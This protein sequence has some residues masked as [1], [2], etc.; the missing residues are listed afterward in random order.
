MNKLIEKLEELEKTL[1]SIDDELAEE[2]MQ[3]NENSDLYK[4][5]QSTQSGQSIQDMRNQLEQMR[6][7]AKKLKSSITIYQTSKY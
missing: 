3:C 2:L 5:Y 6:Q 7:Q 4:N 1:N